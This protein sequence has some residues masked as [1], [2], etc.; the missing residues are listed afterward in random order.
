MNF[1]KVKWCKLLVNDNVTH[2]LM[3]IFNVNGQ[4]KS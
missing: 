4:T 1:G 2:L 3:L